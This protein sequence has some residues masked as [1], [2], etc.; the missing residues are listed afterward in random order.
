M[1]DL[2]ALFI[3][4]ALGGIGSKEEEK[5]RW[6]MCSLPEKEEEPEKE[7]EVKDR[8][9]YKQEDMVTEHML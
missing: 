6:R 4:A 3:E 8:E 7:T 9:N 2:G 1:V 5:M